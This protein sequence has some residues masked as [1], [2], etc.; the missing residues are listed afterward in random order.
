MALNPPVANNGVPFRVQGEVFLIMRENVECDIIYHLFM[1]S[2][3]MSFVSNRLDKDFKS[4]D[5]PLAFVRK[6]TF[7]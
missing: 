3:R 6:E 5:I 7:E 1:T 4:F 2:S